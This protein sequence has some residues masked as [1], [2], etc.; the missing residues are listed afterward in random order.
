MRRFLV[1]QVTILSVLAVGM[2]AYGGGSNTGSSGG[3]IS[4]GPGFWAIAALVVLAIVVAVVWLIRRYRGRRSAPIENR[5][6]RRGDR[7][8]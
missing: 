5:A 4:Y 7:A 3:G 8:A 2:S 6:S 1:F